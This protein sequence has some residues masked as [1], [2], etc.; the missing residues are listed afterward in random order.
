MTREGL[1]AV[2]AAWV[3][4]RTKKKLSKARGAATQ[5]VPAAEKAEKAAAGEEMDDYYACVAP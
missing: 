4:K 1:A 2:R 3:K 5:A